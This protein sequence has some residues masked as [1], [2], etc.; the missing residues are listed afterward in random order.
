MHAGL[1]PTDDPD[2][3][4]G[5]VD[6]HKPGRVRTAAFIDCRSVGERERG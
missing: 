5:N 6:S 2:I 1:I 4:T 3:A